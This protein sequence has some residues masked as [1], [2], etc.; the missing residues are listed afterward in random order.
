MHRLSNSQTQ[1]IISLLLSGHSY[2]YIQ[3]QTGCGRATISHI[4]SH[5]CS[6]IPKPSGG[7]PA[8]LTDSNI[9]YA[10]HL[11]CMGKVENAVQ[12]TKSLQDITNQP[13]TPQTLCNNLKKQNWK[14]VVKQKR[15]FLKPKH[16]KARLEF[17]ERHLEWTVEDWKRVWWSDET[18]IN[19]LGS[20]GRRYVWKEIGEGLSD[21]VVEGTVKFGGGNL[22]MWGCMGW[23]GVGY[24]CKIDGKMD[25]DLYV[26]IV[27]EE[28]QQTLEFYGQEVKDI[29]FQQD[30]DPK[31][32]SKKAKKWFQDNNINVLQWP[33][34]SPDLN[35]IE[36]LW[37][38]LKKKLRE[39]DE[40][41]GGV[42][43]LWERVQVQWDNIAKEE[44]QKLIESMPNRVKAVIK[45][46]GGYTKY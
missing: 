23:E 35:P 16:R 32:T 4:C 25:S 46:K 41:T 38:H 37:H 42:V 22:M 10:K 19:H 17:A 39:Y 20:D 2:S 28:F 43:E 29:I 40:P 21:R 6:N 33:A 3:R 14:A 11:M 30:N 9:A 31:H 34:Q 8:K 7:R 45:A 1:E 27:E 12:A 18:K 15:P 24:A 13:I 5:H 44:C 36:H 26:S